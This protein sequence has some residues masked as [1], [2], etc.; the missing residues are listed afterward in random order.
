MAPG[1]SV[2][3]GW[4]EA[5]FAGGWVRLRLK[6][7]HSSRVGSQFTIYTDSLTGLTMRRPSPCR[8]QTG[9]TNLQAAFAG[10]V[11]H[12]PSAVASGTLRVLGRIFVVAALSAC[13]HPDQ[14]PDFVKSSTHVD[15]GYSIAIPPVSCGQAYENARG[16]TNFEFY[17]FGKLFSRPA[18]TG[19]DP[20]G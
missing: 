7:V 19:R 5:V 1:C 16:G 18:Q 11:A 8:R 9:L 12:L 20:F 4:V 14:Q 10:E 15:Y 3:Q 2:A 17:F 13:F 6:L